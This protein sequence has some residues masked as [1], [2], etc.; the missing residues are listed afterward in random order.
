MLKHKN[1]DCNIF[2]ELFD[3]PTQIAF[4]QQ[5]LSSDGGLLLAD[6]A[7]RKLGLTQALASSLPETR[8]IKIT[9]HSKDALF[10]QRIL[11]L[12]CGYED[13]NDIAITGDDPLMRLVVCKD[14][15]GG[16]LFY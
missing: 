1:T 16:F 4:D 10:R 3:R 9:L 7:D 13:A 6:L 11:S 5:K 8:R 12:A 14:H 2:Q 15:D